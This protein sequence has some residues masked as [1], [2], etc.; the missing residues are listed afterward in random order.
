MRKGYAKGM[1][2]VLAFFILVI[3]V[4]LYF[5]PHFPQLVFAGEGSVATWMSGALLMISA[6]LCLVS[7]MRRNNVDWFIITVFFFILA[8]DERF[9]FHEQLKT[10]I[11][12]VLHPARHSRWIYEMP[13][14]AGAI[15]GAF[16]SWRLWR[17]LEQPGRLLL[18][19]AILLGSASVVIDILAKGV[20]PEEGC[21]LVAELL[22]VCALLKKAGSKE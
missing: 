4:A 18:A 8:L 21:K 15:T 11:I 10:K 12:F 1:A 9:M 2:I 19:A 14:I 7:F 16:I 3:L 17:Q 13:V 22:V 6:T 20:L 5:N